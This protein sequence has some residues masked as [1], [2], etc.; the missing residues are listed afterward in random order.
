MW[1][2]AC[3][4]IFEKFN[5]SN[6]NWRFDFCFRKGKKKEGGPK[7]AITEDNVTK[8]HESSRIGRPP[9]E[10]ARDS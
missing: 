3:P 7:T 4:Q 10:V 8:F 2:P 9:I 5:K 1:K 6:I